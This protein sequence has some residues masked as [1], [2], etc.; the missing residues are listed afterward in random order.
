MVKMELS[1]LFFQRYDPLSNFYL[2][3][4][5]NLVAPDLM[6]QR[7]HPRV[8]SIAWILWHMFRVEDAGINRFITDRPQVLDEGGWMER[9]NVP[10]RHNGCEMTFAEV[11]DFSR[12]INIDGLHEYS[13]AVQTRTR[14]TVS[15]LTM[16]DMDAVMEEVH[17]RKILVDE[18]LA[19]SNPE[20]F[21]Q[22]YLNWSKSK[23]LFS[24]ALTHPYQHFGE[25]S[26]IA[27]LLG[28][29]FE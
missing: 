25:I 21:I 29:T 24:F 9:M 15:T 8:N 16:R 20:G 10:Y 4:I 19:H 26:T 14:E 5:W 18:G 11:D 23:V 17:L 13:L 3:D 22:N 28:V 12:R 27:T 1:Q 6:T 2:P 7:P